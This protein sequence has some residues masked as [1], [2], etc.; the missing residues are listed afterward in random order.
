IDTTILSNK[1][2]M[3]ADKLSS[4][5]RYNSNLANDMRQDQSNSFDIWKDRQDRQYRQ[6]RD[7]L[8]D[9]RYEREWAYNHRK[10]KKKNSTITAG[11]AVGAGKEVVTDY[12]N[13]SYWFFNLPITYK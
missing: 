7:K 2:Q 13:P 11:G 4:K 9:R 1:A 5:A 3:E 10:A 8:E 12:D 6:G